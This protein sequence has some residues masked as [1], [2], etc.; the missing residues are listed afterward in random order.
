MMFLAA[1][2]LSTHDLKHVFV[3]NDSLLTAVVQC[4]V[5]EYMPELTEL[6]YG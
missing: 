4:T 2:V 1:C 3:S 5:I 6:G